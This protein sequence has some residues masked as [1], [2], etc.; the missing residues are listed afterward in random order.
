MINTGLN[1]TKFKN[2]PVVAYYERGTLVDVAQ[3]ED[4]KILEAADFVKLL[5]MYEF[6]K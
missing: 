6:R 5:D 1:H 4:V 3:R 2:V